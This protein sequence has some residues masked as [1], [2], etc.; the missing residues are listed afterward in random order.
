MAPPFL[1][2]PTEV[3]NIILSPLE[4]PHLLA[5][6]LTCQRL[7]AVAEPFLYSSIQW[8][9]TG[10]PGTNLQPLTSAPPIVP[11]LQTIIF[12]P[13][14]ADLIQDV[15]LLGVSFERTHYKRLSSRL[16]V[17]EADVERMVQCV[18]HMNVSYADFWIDELH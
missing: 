10:G 8:T 14:L 2:C 6:C 11:F 13:E 3:L 15:Q 16:Q 4:T 9:W 7:R 1:K 17:T 18:Q 5:L 12:R